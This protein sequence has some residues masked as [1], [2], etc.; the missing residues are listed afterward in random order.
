MCPERQ[1]KRR[2]SGITPQRGSWIL[3]IDQ[4]GMPP[5]IA[6]IQQMASIL[7]GWGGPLAC[8]GH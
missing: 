1:F 4:C 7:A 5:R 3:S 2:V 8:V 6:T